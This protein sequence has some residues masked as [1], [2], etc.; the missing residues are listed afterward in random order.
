MTDVRQRPA[1]DRE[2]SSTTPRGG[3]QGDD[4]AW[5]R[6]GDEEVLAWEVRVE[7]CVR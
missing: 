6:D 1:P 4:D 2:P 3:E 5:E 7:M